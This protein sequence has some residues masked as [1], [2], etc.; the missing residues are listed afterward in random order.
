MEA[1]N[2]ILFRNPVIDAVAFNP[3]KVA[4][5]VPEIIGSELEYFFFAH[6]KLVIVLEKLN[7]SSGKRQKLNDRSL[8]LTFRIFYIQSKIE[9]LRTRQVSEFYLEAE[10]FIVHIHQ[11]IH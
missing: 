6:K 11:R 1:Q 7:R 4:F 3:I 5:Y 2:A 8:Y 10:I 9:E